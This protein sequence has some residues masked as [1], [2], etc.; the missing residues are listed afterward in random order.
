MFELGGKGGGEVRQR[1]EM[2][3][4]VRGA[5]RPVKLAQAVIE[6]RRGSR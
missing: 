1:S 2:D 4:S 5:N 6:V 3:E